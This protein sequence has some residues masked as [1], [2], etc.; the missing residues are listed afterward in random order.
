MPSE[1][2]PAVESSDEADS[3]SDDPIDLIQ[4]GVAST[5][6]PTSYRQSQ[7]HSELWQK[8]CEEEMEAHI[9][10]GTWQIVK[11]PPGKHAICY[12]WL[13]HPLYCV[14][15]TVQGLKPTYFI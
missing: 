14:C 15:V 11:L 4:A 6:E 10:N 1:P 13:K 9:V 7:Q 5:P 12:L 8:A 2:K 3:N